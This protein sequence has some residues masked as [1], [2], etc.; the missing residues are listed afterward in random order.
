MTVYMINEGLA[1][2]NS[3]IEHAQFDRARLFRKHHVDFKLVTS[4][5]LSG[6]HAVLPLFNLKDSES[7]NMFDYFQD[8]LNVKTKKTG[9]NADDID[10]GIDVD[11]KRTG[12]DSLI[13]EARHDTLFLGRVQIRKDQ[14]LDHIEY[15]DLAGNLY[16]VVYYDI[17]GFRS[18]VQY[19]TPEGFLEAENWLKP[20][21]QVAIIKTYFRVRKLVRSNWRIGNRVFDD[22]DDL[23]QYFYNKLN[24]KGNNIF[25]PDRANVSEYQLTHLEKPAYIA[26]I[27]HNCHTASATNPD[28]PLLNDNYEWSLNNV[29]RFNCVISATDKQTRD[30]QKRFGNGKTK[31]FTIPVGV[32][33]DF[34]LAQKRIPMK[35]RKR[36]SMLV[37]ARIAPEKGIEKMI[38]AMRLAQ[39]EIPDLTLDVYG[40][41]DHSNN[42]ATIKG[43]R[44]AQKKLKNPDSVKI[45]KHTSDVASKQKEHQL[46]L[47]YS[48]M[49]GFNLALMEAQSNGMVAI[50][51][52]VNYGPNQLVVNKQNG[53]VVP[54]DDLQ[55]YA[56]AIV[57]IFKD[58]DQ[59]Q[60]MSDKAYELSNRFSEEQVWR[61]WQQVF[62]D[63]H[64]WLEK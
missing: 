28:E 44:R 23:R 7:I 21:G 47:I 5:Y 59:L 8:A 34:E 64:Q 1:S 27:L 16:K 51:N 52:D 39:K 10:F 38:N 13:Y 30:V 40:Y 18:L 37:T 60:K 25:I 19:Y 53:Y 55:E 62:D 31:F 56:K 36:H 46:Y 43:I 11:L 29:D 42:D 41:I 20:N 57:K 48:Q 54:Y 63:Y 17:R 33:P 32:I 14:T 58:D 4:T 24:E 6:L 12:K 26:F 2:Q 49:E 45:H 9:L 61:D 50:A 15:F 22:L 3:G 35:D